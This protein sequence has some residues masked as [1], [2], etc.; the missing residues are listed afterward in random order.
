MQLN[1][2]LHPTVDSLVEIR[3]RI[4][5]ATLPIVAEPAEVK[6]APANDY[7]AKFSAQFVVA[8]CL[9]K[10]RIGLAE[11]TEEARHDGRVRALARRIT[12]E[13]DAASRYPQYMSGGVGLVTADGQCHDAYVAINRGAGERALEREAIVEKFFAAAELGVA[14]ATAARVRDAIFGLET[15]S[16]AELAAALRTG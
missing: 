16:A 5:G 11:L 7:D 10:G 6:A 15:I 3:V 2:E 14:P 12:V 8:T 1:G 9:L 4:P 13:A